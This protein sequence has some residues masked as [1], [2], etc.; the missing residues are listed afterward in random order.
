MLFGFGLC[1]SSMN[2]GV[3]LFRFLCFQSLFVVT[4]DLKR[5]ITTTILLWSFRCCC[6]ILAKLINVDYVTTTVWRELKH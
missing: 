3:K 4:R 5:A 1:C 6:L 2:N